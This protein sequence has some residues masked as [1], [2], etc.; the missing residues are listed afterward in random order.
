M[1]KRQAEEEAETEMVNSNK[2]AQKFKDTVSR[3]MHGEEGERE[4]R[5]N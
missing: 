1:V 3:D 2:Q 4:F 5:A